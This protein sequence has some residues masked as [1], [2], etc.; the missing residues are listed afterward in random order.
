M[1]LAEDAL[2]SYTPAALLMISLPP[3]VPLA[4]QALLGVALALPRR[5]ALEAMFG[6]MLPLPPLPPLQPPDELDEELIGPTS[7]T[8][9][10]VTGTSSGGALDFASGITVPDPVDNPTGVPVRESGEKD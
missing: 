2:W 7:V 8:P 1:V 9:E 10:S 4:V 6:V 5:V 3:P